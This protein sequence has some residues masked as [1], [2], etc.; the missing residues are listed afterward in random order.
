M[1]EVKV[2]HAVSNEGKTFNLKED[3]LKQE[4]LRFKN[5]IIYI[6]ESEKCIY[7]QD[8]ASY[9]FKNAMKNISIKT[10]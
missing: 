5:T 10:K 2:S 6:L 4:R 8:N 7:L 3:E 1:D 9:L